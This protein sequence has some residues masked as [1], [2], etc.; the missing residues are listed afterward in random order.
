MIKEHSTILFQGDSITDCG[1]TDRP[2]EYGAGYPYIIKQYLDAFCAESNI[3]VLNRGI[4]GNKTCDLVGRWQKDCIDLK[5]DYLSILI[6]INEVWRKYDSNDPTPTSD[7]ADNLRK[8]L[9][10][11]DKDCQVILL[12]PFLLPTDPAR[13]PYRED[14]ASKTDALRKIAREFN[15]KYIALDGYFANEVLS[16]KMPCE[17]ISGDGVH[18]TYAGHVMVAKLWIA[19]ML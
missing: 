13:D 8:L 7:Y 12:E 14:L 18:L 9:S 4:S 10:S 5:P 15:T 3:Q 6:G 2:D 17:K 16:N 11:I 19:E 1:R